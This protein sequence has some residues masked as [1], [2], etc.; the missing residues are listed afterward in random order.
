MNKKVLDEEAAMILAMYY[1]GAGLRGMSN[2][3]GV[4][5]ATLFRFLRNKT[6]E[7]YSVVV[8]LFRRS[9]FGDIHMK[10]G[11][12]WEVDEKVA[13]V[14]SDEWRSTGYPV[15]NY[16]WKNGHPVA[17]V[18]FEN[19]FDVKTHFCLASELL[20]NNS[21]EEI[22]RAWLLAKERSGTWPHI[23]K[24]DGTNAHLTAYKNYVPKQ[25]KLEILHKC[26]EISRV[27]IAEGYHRLMNILKL[28]SG[29][30]GSSLW[31][32]HGVFLTYNFINEKES[33]GGYT[34]FEVAVGS[35]LLVENRWVFLLDLVRA[36]GKNKVF[37]RGNGFTKFS[38]TLQDILTSYLEI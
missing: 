14:N 9:Q 4:S 28:D 6:E 7:I 5:P 3:L 32:V 37:Y 20:L 11:Y 33:L 10:L 26:G 17:Q 25:V 36:V 2:E 34:P 13:P 15:Y 38:R 27:N 30:H 22:A 24:C 29:I 18:L 21:A 1:S 35:K 23:I 19:I 8:Q 12:A 16:K 31:L